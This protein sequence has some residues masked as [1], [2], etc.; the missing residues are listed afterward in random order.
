MAGACV[1]RLTDVDHSIIRPQT[2]QI[3]NFS[4]YPL[5]IENQ[6]R[7]QLIPMICG[8]NELFNP[9]QKAIL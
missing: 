9:P 4:D 7:A 3:Y 6:G 2:S 1:L 5:L 8:N